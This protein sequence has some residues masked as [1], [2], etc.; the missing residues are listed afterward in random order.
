MTMT[1]PLSFEYKVC[2]QL[3]SQRSCDC[4]GCSHHPADSELIR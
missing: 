4:V 3:M 2:V 1:M